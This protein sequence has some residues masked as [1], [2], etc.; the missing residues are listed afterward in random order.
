MV[1]Y[2]DLN[3]ADTNI[4]DIAYGSLTNLYH[5]AINFSSQYLLS[6]IVVTVLL[7][8]NKWLSWNAPIMGQTQRSE[9]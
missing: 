1:P 4:F 2:Q 7:V 3:R 6:G 8:V 9:F 5:D